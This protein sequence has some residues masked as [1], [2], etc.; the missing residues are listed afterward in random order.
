MY[1]GWWART[2]LAGSL[3][4]ATLARVV[5]ARAEEDRASSLPAPAPSGPPLPVSESVEYRWYGGTVLLAGL[6]L[7]G[8]T[9][10]VAKYSSDLRLIAPFALAGFAI[11]PTVHHLYGQPRNLRWSLIYNGVLLGVGAV[12]GIL[13]CEWL[14]GRNDPSASGPP[15]SC[16]SGAPMVAGMALAGLAAPVWDAIFFAWRTVPVAVSFVPLNHGIGLSAAG[17]F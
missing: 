14:S 13:L 7:W 1:T 6:G 17:R 5:D 8:V 11:G 4:V 15:E 16:T 10:V 3:L 9:G 2:L 12:G